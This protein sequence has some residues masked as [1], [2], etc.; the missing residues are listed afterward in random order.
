M[1]VLLIN[2]P[3]P[4]PEHYFMSP[5]LGLMYLASILRAKGHKIKILDLFSFE[6]NYSKLLE[7]LKTQ[8]FDV[9]G[10][11]GMSFQHNTIL[12]TSA[13]IK[14]VNPEIKT[15]LGGA[16]ASALPNFLLKNEDIDFL[17]RGEAEFSLPAL[18]NVIDNPREWQNIPGLCYKT[19]E[20]IEISPP[21]IVKNIDLIPIPAWDLINFKKYSSA[22]HGFFFEK[23]PIGR[24]V[25][26]RGCPFSC[27]FCAAH[28]IHSRIWRP[29]SPKRVLSEIDY[30]INKLGIQELHIEDDNF[31]VN[32]ERAKTIL[33]GILKKKYDLSI[34]FP[35][36]LRIDRLDD[37]LLKLMKAAGIY[38]MTFGIESGSPRI[39]REIKKSLSTEFLEKQ[40]KKIKRYGFYSQGF[41]IIGFPYEK[42]EDI[43]A[44]IKF[45]KKIDLDA[46]FFGTYVPLPGSSDF[47]ELRKNTKLKLDEINW[48]QMFSLK[49]QNMSYHLSSQEIE[50]YQRLATRK[51]YLRPRILLRTIG[52][53]HGFKHITSLIKRIKVVI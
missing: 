17:L 29:H 52:R 15:I 49:A 26:S 46:A 21:E 42:R 51:F 4:Q 2:P 10:I 45:A 19:N 16:H 35:N 7:I 9:V 37:E 13:L 5:P 32:L 30:L 8:L 50:Y 39:L 53:I 22:P 1:R 47:Q 36:G 24:I 11:T 44:T 12:K 31:S 33:K 6:E 38:S 14:K 3:S 27:T 25:T 43:E 18:L 48:D 34:A 20:I 28:I 23:E 41:F 40:L